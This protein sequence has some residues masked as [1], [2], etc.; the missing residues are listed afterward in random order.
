MA[1]AVFSTVAAIVVSP[2]WKVAYATVASLTALKAVFHQFMVLSN[3]DPRLPI[4][5]LTIGVLMGLPIL[6]A[7]AK[8][9][10]KASRDGTDT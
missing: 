8:G 5:I 10:P 2:R 4:T 9:Q 3:G 1:A 7:M 6:L